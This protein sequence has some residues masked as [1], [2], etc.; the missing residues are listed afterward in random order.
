MPRH[1]SLGK[2]I[3]LLAYFDQRAE[4]R[5]FTCAP[6]SFVGKGRIELR[7]NPPYELLTEVSS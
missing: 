3:E 5:R 7:T 4:G 2:H 6:L 1:I